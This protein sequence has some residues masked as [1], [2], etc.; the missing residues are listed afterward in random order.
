MLTV[1]YTMYRKTFGTALF[2]GAVTQRS[3]QSLK[4]PHPLSMI[5]CYTRVICDAQKVIEPNLDSILV[6]DS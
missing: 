5:E 2:N 3:N 6:H 4:E 1:Y